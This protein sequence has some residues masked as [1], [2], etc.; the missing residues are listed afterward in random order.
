LDGNPLLQVQTSFDIVNPT[1]TA[2]AQN[3]APVRS[4]HVALGQVIAEPGGHGLLGMPSVKA[5]FSL[6][7]AFAL[8]G[9]PSGTDFTC[10][11]GMLAM[12]SGALVP[13]VCMHAQQQG[14]WKDVDM[15]G[16]AMTT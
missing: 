9:T 6:V 8:H 15:F 14:S 13:M 5:V 10:T 2:T 16:A 7:V 11:Q 12:L 1:L 4:Q 3:R